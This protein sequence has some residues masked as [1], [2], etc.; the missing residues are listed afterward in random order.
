MSWVKYAK[1]GDKVVFLV[2]F[3]KAAWAQALDR[4][5][6]LPVEGEIYTIREIVPGIDGFDAVFLRL[7]EIIN[8][9]IE[10]DDPRIDGEAQFNAARFRPLQSRQT[11]ISSLTALLKTAPAPALEEIV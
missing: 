7:E 11:D 6:Q 1:V 8:P 3:G 10:H 9:V 2:P 5:D 4:G